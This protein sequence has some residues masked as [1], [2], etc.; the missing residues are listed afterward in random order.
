MACGHRSQDRL[1]QLA[2]CISS[3]GG[4]CRDRAAAVGPVIEAPDCGVHL[5]DYSDPTAPSVQKRFTALYRTLFRLQKIDPKPFCNLVR[6]PAR[7][8]A[9]TRPWNAV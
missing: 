2:S 5:L 7:W 6:P 4:L 3:A 8:F 1:W 9:C